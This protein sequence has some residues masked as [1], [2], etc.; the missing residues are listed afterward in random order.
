MYTHSAVCQDEV[1]RSGGM[2][3]L[4]WIFALMTLMVSMTQHQE[5]WFCQS[6]SQQ[7]SAYSHENG[8]QGGG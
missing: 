6:K 5:W 4:S 3:S 2:L 8:E 1:L 7:R